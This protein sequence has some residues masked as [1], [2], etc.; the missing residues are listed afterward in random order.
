MLRKKQKIIL[1]G[2]FL[3]V[4]LLFSGCGCKQTNPNKYSLEL[5]VWGLFDDR[6]VYDSIFAIYTK[7]NPN[8]TKI[9]YRKFTPDTYKKEI[10]EA[11]AA[12]QGPDIFLI[13]NTWLPIFGDKIVPAPASYLNEQKFRQNFV[14]VAINDFLWQGQ[15]YAVPLSVDSLGLYYNKDTFNAAGITNPPKN[16]EEFMADSKKTNLL[17]QGNQINRS[18]AILGT[19][20]NINRATDILGLLMLQS[21]TQMVDENRTKATFDSVYGSGEKMAS[22]GENALNFYTQFA[23]NSSSVYSWNRDMHYSVDAFSEGQAAMMLNYSWQIDT[24]KAKSPNLNFAVAAVPQL[25]GA[26]PMNYANYWAFAV[27]KNKQTVA[28]ATTAA[29]SNDIRINE[30]WKFLTFLTTEPGTTLDASKKAGTV[31]ADYDPAKAYL[32]KT[33]KPSA[34]RDLIE[35]QKQDAKIGVFASGNLI[36]KSWFQADPEAIEAIFYEMINEVNIG[37]ATV[38]EAI[39]AAATRVTQ[40]MQ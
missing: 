31:S 2:L 33:Y 37:K 19:A 15:A 3:C 36:A 22:P 14:D 24:I 17:G 23:K 29:V 32:A 6:D 7:I 4:A 20:Y 10:L 21:G 18:G 40:L 11:L 34:R 26:T 5:E 28:T 35:L 27:T 38:R 39:K 13:H 12:G 1:S 25:T 8:V 16:W 9:N 30:A